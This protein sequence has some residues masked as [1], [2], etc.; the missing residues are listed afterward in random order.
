VN[1][2]TLIRA[3]QTAEATGQIAKAVQLC[4]Q[5]LFLQPR[6]VEA[7]LILGA[8]AARQGRSREAEDYLRRAVTANPNSYDANRWLTTLLI[9][10]NGGAEAVAFG[11]EAVRLRPNDGEA[12]AVL[13]LAAMGKGESALAIASFRRATELSPE[14][15]GAYH[16]LGVAFQREESFDEA[17]DAFTKAIALSPTVAESYMHL[18]RCFL[19]KA[20]GEEALKCAETALKLNP[21]SKIARQLFSDARYVAVQGENGQRYIAQAIQEDPMSAF[22]HALMASR[23]QEQGDF[24]G[25]EESIRRSTELQP[26]QGFAYYSLAHNR[27][28]REG[29]RA[30]IERIDAISKEAELHSVEKQFIHFALGKMFDDLGEYERAIRHLDLAHQDPG[31]ESLLG[32]K[33]DAER[34]AAKVQRFTSFFTA[35]LLD[36]FK[37][38]GSDSAEP[39]FIFG[40]PRSGTTLLEQ[41]VSRHSQV[42]GG[43]ELFF[44]RDNVRPIIDISNDDIVVP[45]LQKAAGRYLELIRSISPGV[46]HVTD[47]FP[48]NYVYLGL[49]HLAFPNSKFIHARRHPIDTCLSMYMRPFST[50]Q[51]LGRT[52][53]QIV[54]TYRLYLKLMEHWRAT[55]APNRI[56]EVQYEQLVQ[57]PEEI[58]RRVIAHCGL[59][60]EDACLRPQEGDRRVITFS[61]WQVRQP[62]YTTSV[63]R[64]RHY[65][66]WL[67]IFSELLA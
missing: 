23:L 41:I 60:W 27:K 30:L 16:N 33:P 2:A 67:D 35:E 1:V 14:M 59:D 49:L 26:N 66:P 4:N 42:G 63:E 19:A 44:W 39:I 28:M 64:W 22:P 18:G 62:V 29:D 20:Q 45:E 31:N 53:R 13:G 48:S 6:C 8:I 34:Q 25:A 46:D 56:I 12:H 52:R 58:T 54:E 61:K 55:F 9:G 3:A 7:L 36:R 37:G 5:A 47:K 11:Q 10:R 15:S 17:I 32:E 21:N 24:D 57:N 65:E 40:M 38:V 51:G 43:G 50:N